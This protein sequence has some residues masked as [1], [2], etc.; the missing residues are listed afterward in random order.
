[1]SVYMCVCVYLLL[2]VNKNRIKKCKSRQR[3]RT[4][5]SMIRK[6]QMT[7]NRSKKSCSTSQAVRKFKLE[8]END[9]QR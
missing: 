1:M 6:T 3:E 4:N 9:S 5:K 7:N 8:I 2:E